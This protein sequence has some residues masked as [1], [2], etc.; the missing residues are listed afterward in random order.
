MGNSKFALTV[1]ECVWLSGQ[2]LYPSVGAV[3][4]PAP[5][6]CPGLARAV[7]V[8]GCNDIIYGFGRLLRWMRLWSLYRPAVLFVCF[9]GVPKLF[10]G[11]SWP[12]LHE[13]RL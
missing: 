8:I 10:T 4:A 13:T 7:K 9:V 2:A 6:P 12:L 1:N 11:H 3:R 5:Q